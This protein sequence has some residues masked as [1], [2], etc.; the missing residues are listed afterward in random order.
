MKGCGTIRDLGKPSAQV[1]SAQ[2]GAEHNG[3]SAQGLPSAG[4]AISSLPSQPQRTH[5]SHSSF[6]A[7]LL[8]SDPQPF[9]RYQQYQIRTIVST[10]GVHSSTSKLLQIKRN[11]TFHHSTQ[12]KKSEIVCLIGTPKT[13]FLATRSCPCQPL[14]VTVHSL[15]D[16]ESSWPTGLLNLLTNG[17]ANAFYFR[18]SLCLLQVCPWHFFPPD[19]TDLYKP[20]Y[21]FTGGLA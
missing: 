9:L 18:P 6:S 12:N 10:T 16:L 5:L 21:G 11:E 13:W 8:P 20:H 19:F 7:Q 4:W 14:R 2:G 17:L 15:S 1:P 3:K